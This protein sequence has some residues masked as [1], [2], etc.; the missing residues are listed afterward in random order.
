MIDADLADRLDD[1][2]ALEEASRRGDGGGRA[3]ASIIAL[4][5]SA[6]SPCR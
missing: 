4:R 1:R 2:A 5:L 6:A 3:H